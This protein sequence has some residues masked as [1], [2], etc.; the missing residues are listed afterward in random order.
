M[1][2]KERVA[3]AL[4]GRPVDRYPVAALYSF[5]VFED[6]F[7][8]LTGEPVWKRRRVDMPS[9]RAPTRRNSCSTTAMSTSGFRS[10]PPR[11]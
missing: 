11:T 1:Q 5:L 8:D 10:C 3:A 9:M 6:R 7:S 2:N 4:E